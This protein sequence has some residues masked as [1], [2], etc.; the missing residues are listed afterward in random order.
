M[1]QTVMVIKDCSVKFAAVE[2]DLATTAPDFTCQVTSLAITANPN[3]QTV[4]ATFC[5]AESQAPAATGWQMDLTWL[6]DWSVATNGMSEF[7]FDNDAVKMFFEVTPNDPEAVGMTGECWIVAGNYLGDAGTP[8][9][10]SATFPLLAK[11]TKVPVAG[12]LTA[13]ESESVSA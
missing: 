1:S 2:A 7:M 12:G 10:A 11:P 3:L 9:T 4:P 13:R 6:Q 8:L 5:Q